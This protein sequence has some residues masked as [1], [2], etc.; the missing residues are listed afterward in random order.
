MLR[1]GTYSRDE[2]KKKYVNIY[3]KETTK[4]RL[5]D[6]LDTY[7][8]L[9]ENNRMTIGYVVPLDP[10]L[11][12]EPGITKDFKLD[13]GWVLSKSDA[14]ELFEDNTGNPHNNE[15]IENYG[16]ELLTFSISLD[17]T[18]INVWHEYAYFFKGGE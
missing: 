16:D 15:S 3:E 5:S 13:N 7:Y 8:L 4:C 9:L 17:G 10:T 1:N 12:V 11:I 6:R 2:L 14:T 18:F